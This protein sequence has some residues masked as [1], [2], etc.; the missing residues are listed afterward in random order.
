MTVE[1][2]GQAV[3]IVG[4]KDGDILGWSCKGEPAALN[5]AS[6]QETWSVANAMRMK[7]RPSST[8]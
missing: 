1:Q 8:S 4:D 7:K 2:V 6:S 3:E 5:W